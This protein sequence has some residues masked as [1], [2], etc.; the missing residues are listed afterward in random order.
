MEIKSILL[1]ACVFLSAAQAQKGSRE[2]WRT[3]GP[4]NEYDQ[5]VN[6]NCAVA[7]RAGI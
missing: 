4:C 6:S 2:P 3:L 7:Y 5:N 1:A